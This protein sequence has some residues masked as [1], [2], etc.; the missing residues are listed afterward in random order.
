MLQAELW[1]E[2][3]HARGDVD[4]ETAVRPVVERVVVRV[5]ERI[6]DRGAQIGAQRIAR[7]DRL[8][9]PA[10][11]RDGLIDPAAFRAD[12]PAPAHAIDGAPE[13]E[14]SVRRVAEVGGEVCRLR[15][16]REFAVEL[17][18]LRGLV[19]DLDGKRLGL[20][21]LTRAE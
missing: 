18:P 21:P 12:V 2:F 3:H 7:L 10:V 17:Q 5:A 9:E 11:A 19:V 20:G 16:K 1:E 8:T 4:V 13:R 6:P 15:T 14:R